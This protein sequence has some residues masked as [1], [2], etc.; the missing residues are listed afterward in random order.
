MFGEP[1]VC[2]SRF[3]E[4]REWSDSHLVLALFVDDGE[5]GFVGGNNGQRLLVDQTAVTERADVGQVVA[6]L[7]IR[8]SKITILIIKFYI[9]FDV[10]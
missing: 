5:S 10:F 2:F 3:I 1:L 9:K 7:E 6:L 4:L 8:K